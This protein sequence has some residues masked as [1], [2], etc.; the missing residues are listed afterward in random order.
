[1]RLIVDTNIVFS[2]ILNSES[3]I[4]KILVHS[5]RKFEF[6]SPE[7]LKHEI[8]THRSKLKKYLKLEASELDELIELTTSHIRFINESL[9]PEKHWVAASRLLATVDPMDAHSSP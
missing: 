9:I 8:G 7:F 3:N 6:Y 1:M 4:S 2:G 5:S